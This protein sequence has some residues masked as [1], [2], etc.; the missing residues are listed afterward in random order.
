MQAVLFKTVLVV[1]AIL[2][3]GGWLWLLYAA[4]KWL[5]VKL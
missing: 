3:T 1:A 5:I 4:L 2:A